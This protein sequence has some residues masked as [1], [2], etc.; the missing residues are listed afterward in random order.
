MFHKELEQ[1]ITRLEKQFQ[2]ICDDLTEIKKE[3]K[4]PKCFEA[5]DFLPE[6]ALISLIGKHLRAIEDYLEIEIKWDYEKDP[7]YLEPLPREIRVF[8]AVKLRKKTSPK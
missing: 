5:G 8:R 6:N 7:S 1:R 3:L 4:E 2:T